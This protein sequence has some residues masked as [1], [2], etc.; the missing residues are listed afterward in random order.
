MKKTFY[1]LLASSLLL[2]GC[3]SNNTP[4]SSTETAKTADT[5]KIHTAPQ[6]PLDT[7]KKD[8]PITVRYPNGIVKEKSNYTD[9][10]RQG[11]C[12]SFYPSGK[13][14]SDDHFLNGQI[15]GPTVSYFENGKKRYEGMCAKGKPTGEW[16]Y[17]DS[18]GKLTRTV[19][20]N[21]IPVQNHYN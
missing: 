18:S 1:I 2:N 4:G 5:S 9:G 6:Q 16:K 8:G 15:D 13:L 21:G 10:R 7:G 17:Y 12:Q 19:N 14:W 3:H 20:Y 11:E